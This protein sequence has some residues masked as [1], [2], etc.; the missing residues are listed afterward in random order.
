MTIGSNLIFDNSIVDSGQLFKPHNLCVLAVTEHVVRH[1]PVMV[2]AYKT[3]HQDV[4]YVRRLQATGA[5]AGSLAH[6]S[7]LV[8]NFI[9]G[10]N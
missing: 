5:L 4:T 1:T 8:G 3:A 10:N 6:M 9:A 2:R 7:S